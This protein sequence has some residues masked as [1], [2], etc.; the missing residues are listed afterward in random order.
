VHEIWIADIPELQEDSPELV[1]G[2]MGIQRSVFEKI[3]GFGEE[4]GAGA[5]G[6]KE[7]ALLWMQMKEARHSERNGIGLPQNLAK[8]PGKFLFPLPG[9]QRIDEI[10]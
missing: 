6:F 3:D 10:L 2:D 8:K 1:G 9:A 7:E 5:T 4:F